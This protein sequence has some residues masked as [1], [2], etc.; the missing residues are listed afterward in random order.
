MAERVCVVG[1]AGSDSEMPQHSHSRRRGRR[2]RQSARRGRREKDRRDD[3][4]GR[5]CAAG[6]LD[7]C[8]EAAGHLVDDRVMRRAHTRVHCIGGCE[9]GMAQVN[10]HH[11][12][13]AER[14]ER[15]D[16]P[17]G[18]DVAAL[19]QTRHRSRFYHRSFVRQPAELTARLAGYI[20]ARLGKIVW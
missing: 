5:G 8:L 4:A 7:L 14:K 1:V 2:A 17:K 15:P 11:H 19:A 20:A 18:P 13:Q 10:R 3:A 16:D 9:E 12:G 6:A